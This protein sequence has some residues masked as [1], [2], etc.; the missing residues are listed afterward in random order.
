MRDLCDFVYLRA[1]DKGPLWIGLT[2]LSTGLFQWNYQG[3][4]LSESATLTNGIYETINSGSTLE[5][6]VTYP[7]GATTPQS[8]L[9]LVIVDPAANGQYLA[10]ISSTTPDALYLIGASATTVPGALPVNTIESTLGVGAYLET[11]VWTLDPTTWNLSAEWTR[12]VGA[13]GNET[14][15]LVFMVTEAPSP[16]LTGNSTAFNAAN[17]NDPYTE[18]TAGLE[19][20]STCRSL[21]A[22][23]SASTDCCSGLCA[24]DSV[25]LLNICQTPSG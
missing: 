6:T 25:T 23:C 3:S 13:F 1:L 24:P 18:V 21:G 22:D 19:V 12:P 20:L 14:V 17:V 15:P 7:K 2:R 4:A 9:N 8:G 10:L 5:V 11:A 16:Y